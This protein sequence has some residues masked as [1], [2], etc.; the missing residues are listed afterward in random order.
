MQ[1]LERVW[2]TIPFPHILNLSYVQALQLVNERDLGKSDSRKGTLLFLRSAA[3]YYPDL[4]YA[5]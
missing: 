2:D 3:R 4:R 1:T 5:F